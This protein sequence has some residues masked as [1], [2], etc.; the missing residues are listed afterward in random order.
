MIPEDEDDVFVN[1]TA[2]DYPG[3][4]KRSTEEAV[5]PTSPEH[6]SPDSQVALAMRTPVKFDPQGIYPPGACVFAAKYF[7]VISLS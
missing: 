1:R 6:F 3:K 5:W 7:P 2:G 4:K